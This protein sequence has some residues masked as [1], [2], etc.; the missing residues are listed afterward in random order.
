ME[1]VRIHITGRVQGV[2]YRKSAQVEASNLQLSGWVRN[3]SN[4]T[5]LAEAQGE[6][7]RL[8]QFIQWCR[9]GP[10]MAEVIRVDTR[11]IP[12]QDES[13]FHILR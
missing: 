7:E 10:I 4:G 6:P 1:R 8:K 12:L 11:M 9:K 5:V 3:L 2:F 13:G